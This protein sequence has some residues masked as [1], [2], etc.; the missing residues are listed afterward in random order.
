[1][2]PGSRRGWCLALLLLPRLA[3]AQPGGNEGRLDLGLKLLYQAQLATTAR[4]R[5]G[6]PAAIDRERA[7]AIVDRLRG[8]AS[9]NRQPGKLLLLV[10]YEGDERQL[11]AAGF[12]VQ[13]RV[14]TI[15]SG[16]LDVERLGELAALPGLT[17]AELSRPLQ[18][19]G[20]ADAADAAG[21]Q[22]YDL[23]ARTP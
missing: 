19:F 21:S 20:A 8:T 22:A 4:D 14:G 3:V 13:A 18:G 5:I 6:L 12:A 10:R 1:M 23:A 16:V 17:A 9:E 15:Y 11:A 7:F 2:R